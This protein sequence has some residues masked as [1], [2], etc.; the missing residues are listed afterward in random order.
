M[1]AF[2]WNRESATR[3]VSEATAGLYSSTYDGK[4]FDVYSEAVLKQSWM[5]TVALGSNV[6][7]YHTRN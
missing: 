3:I 5:A 6:S 1:A 7:A 2:A 4:D